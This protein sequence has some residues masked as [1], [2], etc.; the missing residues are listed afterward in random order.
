MAAVIFVV[1]AAGILA[2]VSFLRPQGADSAKRLQAAYMGKRIIDRLRSEVAADTWISG[3]FVSG[4]A[5]VWTEGD[6]TINYIL[7]DVPAG[8]D[9]QVNCMAKKLT[10]KISYPE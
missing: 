8:C 9:L 7:E 6:Y 4:V 3:N 5:H 1:A 10:L 2:T